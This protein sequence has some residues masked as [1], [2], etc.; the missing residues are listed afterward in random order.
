MITP[1][2]P[3]ALGGLAITPAN[4]GDA[5][6]WTRA[7]VLVLTTSMALLVRS[8]STKVLIAGSTKLMSNEVRPPGTLTICVAVYCSSAG[9]AATTIISSHG[10]MAPARQATS[11]TFL[12]ML[13]SLINHPAPNGWWLHAPPVA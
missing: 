3:A 4:G 11:L 10:A 7:F 8:A 1:F 9:V 5:V 12:D 2:G 13:S 6:R